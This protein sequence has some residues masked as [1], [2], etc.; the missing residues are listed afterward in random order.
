MVGRR[1]SLMADDDEHVR[2]MVTKVR[3]SDGC[4][5]EGACGG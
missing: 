2:G 1:E 5:V 3:L 4:E